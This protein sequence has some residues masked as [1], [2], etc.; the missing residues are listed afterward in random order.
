MII[1]IMFCLLSANVLFASQIN[2]KTELLIVHP[3]VEFDHFNSVKKEIKKLLKSWKGKRY[4]LKH[5][6]SE[7]GKHIMFMTMKSMRLLSLEMVSTRFKLK[8][9]K[10][11]LWGGIFM[12]VKI[13]P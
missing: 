3:S 13:M 7:N 12:A 11:L 4:L 2:K 6:D 1:T 10:S 5:D 8:I 9:M